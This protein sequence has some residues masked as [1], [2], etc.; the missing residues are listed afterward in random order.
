MPRLCYILQ[1][2]SCMNTSI[3]DGDADEYY[4]FTSRLNQVTGTTGWMARH[5]SLD[6]GLIKRVI[7]IKA[8]RGENSYR[9]R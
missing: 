1:D 9:P 8:D 2:V 7:R 6:K 3:S 5:H 4:P